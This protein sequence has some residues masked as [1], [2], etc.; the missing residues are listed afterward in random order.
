MQEEYITRVLFFSRRDL[1]TAKG[2][3]SWFGRTNDPGFQPFKHVSWPWMRILLGRLVSP[4][5]PGLWA[6]ANRPGELGSHEFGKMETKDARVRAYLARK[7]S[8]ESKKPVL[9]ALPL[10]RAEQE[11]TAASEDDDVDLELAHALRTMEV[12]EAI[13]GVFERLQICD[14]QS[15]FEEFK[16]YLGARGRPATTVERRVSLI[17]EFSR[18][19]R[20]RNRRFSLARLCRLFHEERREDLVLLPRPWDWLAEFQEKEIRDAAHCAYSD[21]LDF[22]ED[23]LVMHRGRHISINESA[24]RQQHLQDIERE[25]LARHPFIAWLVESS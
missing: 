4:V 18:H 8:M 23:L 2:F 17:G 15:F 19:N 22:L 13:G 3:I 14:D 25:V 6:A 24:S 9:S 10:L 21:L 5:Q 1:E 12:R 20:A 16:V 11:D 7:K